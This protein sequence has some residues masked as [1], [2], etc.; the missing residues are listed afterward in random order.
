MA[1]SDAYVVAQVRVS[2]QT[3]LMYAK[4]GLV[5]RPQCRHPGCD[6]TVAAK[7]LCSMHYNQAWLQT[8]P[9]KIDEYNRRARQRRAQREDDRNKPNT[10]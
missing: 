3:A 7:G 2:A 4:K 5:G 9:G 10:G 1:L 8:K 6:R